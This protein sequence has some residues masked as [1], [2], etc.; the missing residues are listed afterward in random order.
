MNRRELLSTVVRFGSACLGLPGLASSGDADRTVPGV[1][2]SPPEYPRLNRTGIDATVV[3]RSPE[4]VAV[5]LRS[6]DPVDVVPVAYE[7]RCQTGRVVATTTGPRL[8]STDGLERTL[9]FEFD[10][11]AGSIDGLRDRPLLYEIR[12]RPA[13]E[14]GTDDRYLCESDPL[15]RRPSI[16]FFPGLRDSLP[17]PTAPDRLPGFARSEREGTYVARFR[18][19]GVD[20][21][22]QELEYAIGKSAYRRGRR[23]GGRYVRTFLESRSNPYARH[24]VD[25]LRSI[26]SSRESVGEHGNSD[27]TERVGS[28]EPSERRHLETAV[29]FVQ[30]LP[31]AADETTKG[32]HDYHR[33]VEETL[34]DGRGDCKDGTY[35]LAGLLSQAPFEYETALVFMPN[36]VVLGVERSALPDPY[37]D[38]ETVGES[39]Y[40]PIE[41]TAER[42]IGR[43]RDDPIVAIFGPG[44]G[45][46]DPG[47]AGAVLEEQARLFSAHYG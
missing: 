10:G 7:R 11:R 35:L 18:W 26:S 2:R 25:R 4:S 37:G 14:P 47:S 30:S 39:P 44:Y 5:R 40:V 27:E 24:L 8:R 12:V 20:D 28:R 43:V 31:Y 15:T 3:E 16:P 6:S 21:A 36:H 42:P 38:C 45:F 33:T 17:K 46:V 34:V 29:R 1:D 22:P 41:T 23:R 32:V 9:A 19:R 13:G